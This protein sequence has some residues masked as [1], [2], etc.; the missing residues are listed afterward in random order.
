MAVNTDGESV[1]GMNDAFLATLC[2]AVS[3]PCDIAFHQHLV[4]EGIWR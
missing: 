2:E 4:S 1:K 3:K